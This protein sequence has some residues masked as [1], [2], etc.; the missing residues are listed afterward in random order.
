MV[1]SELMP[2][3]LEKASANLVAVVA[4]LAVT[5]MV[6][7]QFL[8]RYSASTLLQRPLTLSQ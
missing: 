7:F 2:D 1:F 4:T 8:V 3:A 5:A 6:A